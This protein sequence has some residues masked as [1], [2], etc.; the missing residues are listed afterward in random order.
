MGDHSTAIV[1]AVPK[2]CSEVR[3]MVAFSRVLLFVGIMC[4]ALAGSSLIQGEFGD[5]LYG[6]GLGVFLLLNWRWALGRSRSPSAKSH[7]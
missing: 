1:T 3:F 2:Q 7:V 5:A 6:L 4:L